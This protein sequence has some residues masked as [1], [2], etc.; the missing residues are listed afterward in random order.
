[1]GL[2]VLSCVCQIKASRLYPD[3]RI[4]GNPNTRSRR[5]LPTPTSLLTLGRTF[6][7]FLRKYD[8]FKD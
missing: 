2:V 8:A 7:R 4:E 5:I 1:M 6:R 3:G